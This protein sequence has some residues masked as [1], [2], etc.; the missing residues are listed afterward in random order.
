MRGEII[1]LS[2]V[3][4]A[5]C[6]VQHD[7]VQVQGETVRD[8]ATGKLLFSGIETVSIVDGGFVPRT[9]EI[10]R[11][12]EVNWVNLDRT[13]HTISFSSIPVDER[14]PSGAQVSMRF[15]EAGEFEYASRTAPRKRG[16][17][18]VK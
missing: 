6:T 9:L 14:I 11:G 16:Y 7:S 2:I 8:E 15:T 13:G 17:I 1:L 5:G 12:T 4:L 18:I 10:G 3:L